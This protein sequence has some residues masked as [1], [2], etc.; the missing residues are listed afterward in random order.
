MLFEGVVDHPELG[1][2]ITAEVIIGLGGADWGKLRIA[3]ISQKFSGDIR[4]DLRRLG[5]HVIKDLC[6]ARDNPDA[7]RKR[8]EIRYR[9]FDPKTWEPQDASDTYAEMVEFAKSMGHELD[10]ACE[11]SALEEAWR[12]E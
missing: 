8:L 2:V 1:P 7:L 12:A 3:T 11:A 6:D 9:K 4:K 10:Q 5:F